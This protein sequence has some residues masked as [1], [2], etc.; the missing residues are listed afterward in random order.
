MAKTKITTAAQRD[1]IIKDVTD[2][3]GLQE[4]KKK[5]SF[6]TP[7]KVA[8]RNHLSQI[9]G[10]DVVDKYLPIKQ[11]K[12]AEKSGLESAFADAVKGLAAET[13]KALKADLDA[14]IAK[15]NAEQEK[16]AKLDTVSCLSVEELEALLKAKKDEANAPKKPMKILKVKMN[17]KASPMKLIKVTTKK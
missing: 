7:F 15:I 12:Q 10:D 11:R 5:Y 14:L 13:K 3:K 4:F 9:L 17:L 8:I 2:E 1:N 6:S 16:K